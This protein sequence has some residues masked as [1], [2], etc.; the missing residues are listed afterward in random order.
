[1]FLKKFSKF[2]FFCLLV[3]LV[4]SKISYASTT[5]YAWGENIGW[6]NF[7]CSGCNV[8]VQD[9]KITGYAWSENYGWINL[10]PTYGGIKNDGKGNLSGYAWGE[11]LGWINFD[12]VYI[13]SNGIFHGIAYGEISGRI[14][15]DCPHC[16][17]RTDWRP[18][19]DVSKESIL[20][21]PT[22]RRPRPPL[23]GFRVIINYGEKITSST[24]VDLI[25]I[26]GQDAY[27]MA[28]SNFSDFRDAQKEPYVFLKKWDLCKNK[29]TCD[30]GEQ[31][32][33]VKF[34]NKNGKASEVV[35]SSIVYKKVE[36]QDKSVKNE[37]KEEVLNLIP[38]NFKFTRNLKL[39]SKGEDVRYLQILL[40]YLDE[41]I[42]PEGLITGYFGPLTRKAV[43]RFQEKYSKEILEPL[44]LKQ[45]TGVVGPKTREKLNFLL[46]N[47]KNR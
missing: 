2:Y 20:H 30:E 12:G 29:K 34:Y 43:K 1:M 10:N 45:G 39:G 46:E 18:K 40:K 37:V 16:L 25:L 8:I 24:L 31:F 17:V 21:P 14:N 5:G 13:D 11:N 4:L 28:I 42:Y 41:E 19:S 15:F 38:R 7:G 22:F 33:Y 44:G 32:V 36:A 9:D 47:L 35:S 27:E 26:G 6:I 23:G 3:F